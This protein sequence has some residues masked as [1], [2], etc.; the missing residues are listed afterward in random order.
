MLQKCTNNELTTFKYKFAE[1]YTDVPKGC[2]PD[3]EKLYRSDR[4]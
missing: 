2:I 1:N 4:P 3:P